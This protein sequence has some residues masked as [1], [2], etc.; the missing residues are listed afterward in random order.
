[1]GRDQRFPSLNEVA[2]LVAQTIEEAG[3]RVSSGFMRIRPDPRSK[4]VDVRVVDEGESI[5]LSLSG[6]SSKE[7][8]RVRGLPYA[9]VVRLLKVKSSSGYWLE[10]S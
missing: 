4:R 7:E 3:G 6:T 2:N 9:T 5:F 10:T 8:L 1:M